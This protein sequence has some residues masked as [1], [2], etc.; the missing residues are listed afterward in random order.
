MGMFKKGQKDQQDEKDQDEAAG[1]T[2]QPTENTTE[3]DAVTTALAR[4]NPLER[5]LPLDI[6]SEKH[7]PAVARLLEEMN[8]TKRGFSD[9]ALR[10]WTPTEIRVRQALSRNVP[11][12]IRNGQLYNTVGDLIPA[13]FRFTLL[14][15]SKSNI[16]FE[17]GGGSKIECMSLDTITS[18]YGTKCA[19]CADLPFRAGQPTQ[20]SSVLNAIVL[21]EDIQLYII[22]F[23]KTSYKS[24]AQLSKMA[25]KT[26]APWSK[27][28]S[29]E[30]SEETNSNK[31]KYFVLKTNPSGENVASDV[32]VICD[33]L[34]LVVEEL[35][36]KALIRAA[37][38]VVNAQLETADLES[39]APVGDGD[40]VEP[41]F[42]ESTM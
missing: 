14:F 28:Y 32:Q 3:A 5:I 11:D 17:A 30:T 36:A 4:K 13:P 8:P 35:H 33:R 18:R 2:A 41:D 40:I 7:R 27:W 6:V 10:D 26:D 16:K 12:N 22:R 31:A 24:G 19:D 1:N 37:D 21:S 23:S 39:T 20:C 42:S 34:N 38:Q 25:Q 15:I 9:E 29:L